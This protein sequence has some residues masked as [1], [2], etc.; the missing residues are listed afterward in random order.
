[1]SPE[2]ARR[3]H[4]IIPVQ[5]YLAHRFLDEGP[6]PGD[7]AIIGQEWGRHVDKICPKLYLQHKKKET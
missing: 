2:S 4:Q 3:I 7:D 5:L 1:M 6:V